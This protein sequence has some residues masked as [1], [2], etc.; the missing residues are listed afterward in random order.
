MNLS[1][2][3][4]P[5]SFFSC[6]AGAEVQPSC[7]A[8]E[9]C[10]EQA[11][12]QGQEDA[13][14]H[15]HAHWGYSHMDSQSWPSVGVFAPQTGAKFLLQALLQVLLSPCPAGFQRIAVNQ[16][17]SWHDEKGS[18]LGGGSASPSPVTSHHVTRSLSTSSEA[19]S[20]S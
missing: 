20:G 5:D 1:A 8:G 14:T 3:R 2:A 18:G 13:D 17:P 16:K 6:R 15:K 11:F 12:I 7:L 9:P 10:I 19:L 4:K